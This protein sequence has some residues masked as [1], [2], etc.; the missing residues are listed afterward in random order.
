M[1]A[2]DELPG[3]LGGEYADQTH[4]QEVTMSVCVGD[5]FLN[6]DKGNEE[7]LDKD[8]QT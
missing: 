7:I 6:E 2:N 5:D 3:C 1:R 8:F 4:E